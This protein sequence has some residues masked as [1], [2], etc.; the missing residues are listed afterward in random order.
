[1]HKNIQR[2]DAHSPEELYRELYKQPGDGI[3]QMIA[4][5]VAQYNQTLPQLGLFEYK[6]VNERL[7]KKAE[8][9]AAKVFLD[10][11]LDIVEKNMSFK[12]C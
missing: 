4:D 10:G 2:L 8:E 7:I 5:A 12:P 1:M 6:D 11:I 9:D 3:T